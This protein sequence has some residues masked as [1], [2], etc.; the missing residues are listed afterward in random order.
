M[1]VLEKHLPR[2]G[3]VLEIA[4]GSGEH[5][6]FFAPK[7]PSLKWLP[8]DFDNDALV[9][10]KSWADE[11]ENN[12][13]L[14]PRQLNAA[15]EDWPVDHDDDI[16]AIFNAN[17][18]H[19]SP[20]FVAEGLFKGA[21]KYLPRGGVFILYGPFK[22]DGD[23]TS[24]GNRNFD[25]LLKSRDPEWGVRDLADI[26]GLARSAGLTLEHKIDMPSNNLSLIF[27]RN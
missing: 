10:T 3:T 2:S 7:F 9:S 16:Q 24:D 5:A 11:I 17:M 20:W 19:I 12:A 14:Q 22:Q 27:R 8:S 6:C 21:G 1:A 15:S 4:C 23:H 25:A 13:P 18:I 26:D